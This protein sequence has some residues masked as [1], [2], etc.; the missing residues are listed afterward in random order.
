MHRHQ[1]KGPPPNSEQMSRILES[2]GIKLNREQIEQ[3]WRYHNL[4]RKRNEDRD[5]TRI[6]EFRQMVVK[7]YVD[8]LIVAKFTTLPSPLLDIGT[9]AGFPGIPLKIRYPHVKMVLAEHRPRR[10]N[11]LNEVIRELGL[12]NVRVFDHKVVS[13]S[14][15]EPVEG[16]ITRALE[17][18]DKTLLRTSACL[19]VGGR[20]FFLKGPNVDPEIA[21]VKRRFGDKFKL[22]QDEHYRLPGTEH[23]R[24]L[25]VFEKIV[26]R[27]MPKPGKSDEPEP[28][29]DEPLDDSKNF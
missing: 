25:V 16:V 29:D 22:V 20:L 12:K 9:G 19:G 28:D 8:C 11:F 13:R 21:D 27:E 24:R 15:Q 2:S 10:V 26:D 18:I 23:E 3:L 6:V 7:H 17:T 1:K 14:F 5:L 4:L